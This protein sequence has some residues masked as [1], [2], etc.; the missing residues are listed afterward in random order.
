MMWCIDFDPRCCTHHIVHID[1]RG[2]RLWFKSFECVW[3]IEYRPSKMIIK[4]DKWLVASRF[5]H[6]TR[7][8]SFTKMT[9]SDRGGSVTSPSPS[10]WQPAPATRGPSPAWSTVATLSASGNPTMATTNRIECL[11]RDDWLGFTWIASSTRWPPAVALEL[12][13]LRLTAAP[14][15][16]PVS[17][18]SDDIQVGRWVDWI[19]CLLVGFSFAV[20]GG[21]RCAFR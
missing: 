14:W 4:V 20:G 11:N 13:E 1:Y 10:N 15:V 19:F 5:P 6:P 12:E 2:W 9:C 18:I 8:S 21:I 3:G 17:G 7:T 16:S